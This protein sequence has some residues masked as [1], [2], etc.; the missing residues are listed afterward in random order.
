MPMT[1][2]RHGG[3]RD[4]SPELNICILIPDPPYDAEVPVRP[5]VWEIYGNCFPNMGYKVTF[6]MPAREG[7]EFREERFGKTRVVPIPYRNGSLL[8]VKIMAKLLFMW[9]EARISGRIIK[10]ENVD[11]I[12]AK[13]SVFE[14]ILA[15]YLKKKFKIPFAF[16][17]SFPLIEGDLERCQIDRK[18]FAY[19]MTKLQRPVLSF[20]IRRADLILPISKVMRDDLADKGIP[21]EK[22]MPFP[23]GVNTELFS[24]AVDGEKI[25]T[26]YNLSNSKVVAYLGTMDKLRHLDIL[27][28]SLAQL[29]QRLPDIKLL[30]VGDGDDRGNL[31]W[32]AHDLGLGDEAIFTGQVPYLG[33]PQ[34]IAASDVTV[35]PVPP[36]SFIK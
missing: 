21:R 6:L 12:Q 2:R 31:E 3:D 4:N 13:N 5:E 20:I 24:P 34:F 23:T 25:R 7:E 27:I 33:V 15:V 1:A 35:S 9:K 10:Q 8:P 36:W 32:L 16:H 17:Y 30:M 18:K 19:L 22:M 29:K 14:G 11:I 26:R 28:H